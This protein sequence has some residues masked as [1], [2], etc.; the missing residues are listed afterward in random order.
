MVPRVALSLLVS[1]CTLTPVPTI[2]DVAKA[3]AAIDLSCPVKRIATYRAAG[4]LVI[5]RGC[6]VWAQY[7]CSYSGRQEMLQ[8]DPVCVPEPRRPILPAG[9]ASPSPP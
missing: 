8:P 3:R 6:G 4:G 9:D 5:A 7:S 1:A 2:A